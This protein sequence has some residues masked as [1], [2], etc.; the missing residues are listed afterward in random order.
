MARTVGGAP[1]RGAALPEVERDE[2]EMIE[3]PPGHVWVAG[4]NLAWSRDSRFYGP[5]P[6]GLVLGK[7]VRYS[8]P[9]SDWMIDM[10]K[11]G[12]D[13]L[14]PARTGEDMDDLASMRKFLEGTKN[15]IQ[16]EEL[17]L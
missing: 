1:T 15:P 10:I 6:M 2:P 11:T 17:A 16:K 9:A 8:N 4:D 7:V 12:E 5:V 3:V 13:Q 14:R